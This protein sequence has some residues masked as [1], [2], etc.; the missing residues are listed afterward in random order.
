MQNSSFNLFDIA[1][2]QFDKIA[3]IHSL[4][5]ST[6]EFLHNPIRKYQFGNPVSMDNG[7]EKF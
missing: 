5:M 6:G 2:F 4:D 3:N 1:Q 7:I